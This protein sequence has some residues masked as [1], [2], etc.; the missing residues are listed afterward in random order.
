MQNP[1]QVEFK[2]NRK[3]IFL[4]KNNLVVKVGDHVIVQC[5]NGVDMGKVALTHEQIPE[6]LTKDKELRQFIRV[7]NPDEISKLAD[8][9]NEE[10][11]TKA[12]V[13]QKIIKH[14]LKM[15]LVDA[16][17]QFDRKKIVFFFTAE[18]RVDF[19][20]LVKDLAGEFKTRIELRQI[21]VR[22]EAK[23]VDG[24]GP[25]GKQLCCSGHLTE[26]QPITTEYAKDQGLQLNPSKLTGLCG[27]LKCCL[28]YERDF[29]VNTLSR[30]PGVGSPIK[31]KKGR[32]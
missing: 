2:A 30:F 23:R 31:T 27:R 29:Y 25:C 26:F 13:K 3:E 16:E 8:N 24:Y 9:R 14:G 32:G 10:E 22:D 7:A 4:N 21:G 6:D 5:E 12:V 17:Y 1:I 15:K 11:K 19:R 20:S 18:K 28:A